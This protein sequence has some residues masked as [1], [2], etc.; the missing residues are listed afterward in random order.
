MP[1]VQ[2]PVPG[3]TQARAQALLEDGF[4]EDRL[5]DQHDVAAGRDH[6][7]LWGASP[8]ERRGALAYWSSVARSASRPV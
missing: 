4:G 5:G 1:L 2:T 3:T 6:G 7:V 8:D